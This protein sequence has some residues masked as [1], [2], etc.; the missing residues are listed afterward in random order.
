MLILFDPLIHRM[1]F[2]LRE[3]KAWNVLIN[4]L[5]QFDILAL[6]IVNFFCRRCTILLKY[7]SGCDRSC[8]QLREIIVALD[9]GFV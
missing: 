6:I 4:L 7:S 2:A 3:R 8:T 9:I 1:D 5:K